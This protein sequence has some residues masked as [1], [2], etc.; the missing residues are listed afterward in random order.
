MSLFALLHYFI[1][2]YRL[3]IFIIFIIIINN[4]EHANNPR[5]VYKKVMEEKLEKE[6]LEKEK[7]ENKNLKKKKGNAR[8]SG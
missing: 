2:S 3:Y 4:L 7:L 1:T 5:E 6:K 8:K